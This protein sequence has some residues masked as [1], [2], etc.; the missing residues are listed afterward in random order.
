MRL[1]L[2]TTR[3]KL[4]ILRFHWSIL[5]EGPSLLTQTLYT[6]PL[7][8]LQ[9][10][11]RRLILQHKFI[12]HMWIHKATYHLS[13][14]IKNNGRLSRNRNVIE[15][16][17]LIDWSN[18]KKTK[19]V[20]IRLL[21]ENTTAIWPYMV[22]STHPALMIRPKPPSHKFQQSCYS[23]PRTFVIQSFYNIDNPNYPPT[24]LSSNR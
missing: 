5:L 17:R 24:H 8:P 11:I 2:G 12:S 21:K 18:L 3:V 22:Q 13:N 16:E 9:C 14:S 7:F 23:A 19:N 20:E 10:V 4:E 6:A 15:H 1:L